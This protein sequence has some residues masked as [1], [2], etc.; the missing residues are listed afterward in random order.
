[1]FFWSLQEEIIYKLIHCGS[2]VARHIQQTG[3]GV[4]VGFETKLGLQAE[5]SLFLQ[6]KALP[7]T[8]KVISL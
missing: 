4:L 2:C 3:R 6:Q 7:S 8:K 1:M 5:L